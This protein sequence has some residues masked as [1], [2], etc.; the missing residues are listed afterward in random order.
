MTYLRVGTKHLAILALL[1]AILPIMGAAQESGATPQ[2]MQR[3]RSMAAGMS[4][5]QV[6]EQLRRSG[7]NRA[8]LRS[9]LQQYGYD[10]N[11]ADQYFDAIEGEAPDYPVGEVDAEFMEA[12]SAMGINLNADSTAMASPWKPDSSAVDSTLNFASADSAVGPQLFGLDLFRRL[13]T[14]FE[15]SQNGPVDPDYR[16][17]PGDAVS[18][19]LT[20]DVES[21]WNAEVT[22]EG[23]V[24]IPDVG[25]I[26]VNGL[27]MRELREQM[28]YHLGQRFAGVGRGADAPIQFHVGLRSLRTSVVYVIGEAVQPG[29]YPMSSVA[30]V[31]KALYLAGGPSENASFRNI[32]VRRQGQVVRSL[33]I[34]GYLLRGDTSDDIRLEHGD[35]VFLPVSGPRVTVL[36]AVRRPA[37]FE[38]A[39][40]EGLATAIDYAGGLTS[41]AA[42]HRIQIDRILPPE[43][44]KP[45]V[46]RVLIDVDLAALERGEKAADIRDGDVVRVFEVGSDRRNR[47]VVS[48]EVNRPGVYQWWQGLTLKSLVNR[49]DGLSEQAYS[50][51][52]H[53]YRLNPDDG[54]RSLLR[55]TADDMDLGLADRDSVVVHSVAQLANRAF[56]AIEGFVKEPGQYELARDMT[57]Q[58]LILTAGGF[59]RGAYSVEAE[60]ARRPD[61]F[62][63]ISAQPQV[64]KVPLGGQPTDDSPEVFVWDPIPSETRLEPGDHV[65][66]R[67]APGYD[68]L[69][70]VHITGEVQFPGSYALHEQSESVSQLFTRAGGTTEEAYVEGARLLRGGHL[71]ATNMRAALEGRGPDLALMPGDTIEVPQYDPTV[72]V[73]GAVGFESRVRYE[74][75]KGIDYFVDRAGGYSQDADKGR[76]TVTQHNGERR[77]V[78]IRTLFFDSKPKPG[79]GATIH[80]PQKPENTSG[81]DWDRMLTRVLSVAT[82]AATVWLAVDRAG[83]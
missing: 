56:V 6:L 22:R 59:T 39:P 63:G 29:A 5:E 48:G 2:D 54:S 1:L 70:I 52:I 76:T 51:R 38:M 35:V 68:S 30:S 74:P 4:Q 13:T 75:G 43:Q 34:Y 21:A 37:I 8:Q 24:V 27:T 81:I 32:L 28:F 66:V 61:P 20:G 25:Q 71:V 50:S 44:R 73:M 15:T 18:L 79:P 17:G 40:S 47:V 65:F 7:I 46:D 33:D 11:L 12:L 67:K 23:Y 31:L 53:V 82:A 72:L 64:I 10:P 42:S 41:D 58:D 16:L 83:N 55:V 69:G 60:L 9:G 45:G 57:L 78:H 80:V 49:A 62:G 19:I 36:G 14:Q 3:L 77:V 26:F